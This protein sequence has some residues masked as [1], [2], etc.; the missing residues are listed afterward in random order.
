MS[1]STAPRPTSSPSAGHKRA[2][3]A[4]ELAHT[5]LITVKNAAP[6]VPVPY[7]QAAAASAVTILESIQ[8]PVLF[9]RFN[10]L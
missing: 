1:Q 8:V 4:L 2:D 9:P 7:L 10:V 5:V 6:F 3:I